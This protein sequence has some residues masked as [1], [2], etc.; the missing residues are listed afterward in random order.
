M[1]PITNCVIQQTAEKKINFHS[2]LKD[3]QKNDFIEM[4]PPI[5]YN[6]IR[7]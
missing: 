5:S 1:Q 4:F 7:N 3:L 2:K 6:F